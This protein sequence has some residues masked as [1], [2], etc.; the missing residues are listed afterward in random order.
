MTI[1]TIPSLFTPALAVLLAQPTPPTNANFL[2]IINNH[3]ISSSKK[4]TIKL[5]QEYPN[6]IYPLTYN[7]K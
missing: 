5:Q 2:S 6:T 1:Q 3:L 4:P 7:K